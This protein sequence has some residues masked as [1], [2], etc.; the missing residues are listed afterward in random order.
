MTILE[1]SDNDAKA[2]LLFMRYQEK[3]ATL[4]DNRVF[5]VRN[6][7]AELHFNHNGDIAAI[8]L[9]AK[10]FRRAVEAPSPVVLVKK[11]L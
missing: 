5:D 7:S 9:H 10:V 2:F 3:I 6:G 1:L 11:V 4:L 8:D